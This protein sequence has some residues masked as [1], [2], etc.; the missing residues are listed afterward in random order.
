M[1]KRIL[2]VL[3]YFWLG[4]AAVHGEPT[5]FLEPAGM[6][7]LSAGGETPFVQ[8][9]ALGALGNLPETPGNQPGVVPLRLPEWEVGYVQER[10]QP[11]YWLGDS[12]EPPEGVDWVATA[13][14]WAKTK[15][16][17]AFL[18]D[19]PGKAL[20]AARGGTRTFT[21]VLTDGSQ[22]VVPYILGE[23]SAT[24]PLRIFW[25]DNPYNAPQVNLSGKFVRF[26]GDPNVLAL[27]KSVVTNVVAGIEQEVTKV[28]KGLYLDESTHMLS[29]LG[30]VEGQ[31]VMAYYTS[32]NFD[33][34]K[35]VVVVEVARPQVVELTGTIGKALEPSG[36]GYGSTGLVPFPQLQEE[37]DNRGPYYYQHKGQNSYSPKHNNVYPLRPTVG[38]SWRFP[39]YWMEYDAFDTLWPF[40]LCHYACDWGDN[41]QTFVRGDGADPGLPLYL[42][43]DYATT[44]M[45]YQTP[46]GH[47]RMNL[48]DNALEVSL[49]GAA[50]AEKTRQRVEGEGY[51]LLRL[52]ADDDIWFLPIRSVLRSKTSVFP[53]DVAE[54]PVGTELTL[55]QTETAKQN[56][57]DATASGYLYPAASG[58]NYNAAPYRPPE[59]ENPTGLEPGLDD[60]GMLSTNKAP[61]V[62][63][64]VAQARD[65]ASALE[66]WWMNTVQ[67]EGMP[68]P[69]RVP[70][71]P[72][73]YRAVWPGKH[74]TPSII[75][76]SQLGSA[77]RC[78]AAAGLA[79]QADAEAATIALPDG[80]WFADL[81]AG[82]DMDDGGGLAFWVRLPR[83]PTAEDGAFRLLTLGGT[84]P[85]AGK[86]ATYAL[87]VDGSSTGLAL[88][89]WQVSSEGAQAIGS[90]QA[91]ETF[92]EGWNAVFVDLGVNLDPAEPFLHVGLS[93]DTEEELLAD[94]PVYAER[95][96]K[97]EAIRGHAI[98]ETRFRGNAMGSGAG[99]L[100]GKTFAGAAFGRVVFCREWLEVEPRHLAEPYSTN[101]VHLPR[102]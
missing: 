71:I 76:A 68:T 60:S 80:S 64:A 67:E 41:L 58:N 63:Y 77:N 57:A 62:L 9:T 93:V 87:T 30:G 61:S 94:R 27:E 29:A 46:E 24:R 59:P 45:K 5:W 53:D 88:T 14:L 36:G 101:E 18:L 65:P 85:E 16:T 15:D 84:R 54:W 28:T 3:G 20:Y 43:K 19:A 8:P 72:Q 83:T 52:T 90:A 55:R 11:Q 22:R 25:T 31:V 66:V 47:A 74:D 34:L 86:G 102:A 96:I 4:M 97:G 82:E 79:A 73:R 98:M 40:E 75:I 92:H 38:E 42:P 81:A 32:G 37:T 26:Y 23:I 44:L 33:Q 78:I 17:S 35:K 12:I 39:V 91:P 100:Q 1:K 13:A 21:W 10:A 7:R 89:L 56:K 2:W 50:P 69:I 49:A 95:F 48:A 51:S 99:V 6:P 70:C